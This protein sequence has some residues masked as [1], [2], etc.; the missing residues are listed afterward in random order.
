MPDDPMRDLVRRLF[1]K[2]P[3]TAET[4]ATEE[5]DPMRDFVRDLFAP[6]D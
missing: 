5:P 4:P 2:P 1:P 6:I 3:P